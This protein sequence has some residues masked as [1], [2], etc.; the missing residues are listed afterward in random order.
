LPKATQYE[1]LA[2]LG[3]ALSATT[4]ATSRRSIVAGLPHGVRAG[5][6]TNAVRRFPAAL[7]R[8]QRQFP[9]RICRKV[10]HPATESEQALHGRQHFAAH[11]KKMFQLAGDSADTAAAKA[12]AV[13][14]FETILAKASMDRVSMR[15]PAK[16]Y[17]IMTR[18]QLKGLTPW[19]WDGLFLGL[20]TPAFDTLN[21]SQP[22]YF[23]QIALTLAMDSAQPWKAY[24]EYHLLRTAAPTLPKVFEDEDF[25]FWERYLTGAKEP[26]PRSARCVVVVD[27]SL[28]DLLAPLSMWLTKRLQSGKCCWGWGVGSGAMPS[29]AMARAAS[30]LSVARTSSVGGPPGRSSQIP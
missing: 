15:D 3:A 14:D 28:G 12:A 20:G 24:F 16:R 27:R 25:D 23:K 13:L 8:R 17:H 7:V 6:A 1:F 19:D 2:L 18:A 26:R 29:L 5:P 9:R 11:M 22:D 21:V 10:L 30:R 4:V